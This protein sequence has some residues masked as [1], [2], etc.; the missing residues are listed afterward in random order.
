MIIDCFLFFDELDLLE[1]RLHEL[2][3]VVDVFVLTESPITFTGIE[4]PLFFQENKDRFKGFEIV[5][6]VCNDLAVC[7]PMERERIQKQYNLDA[8]FNILSPGD[9]IMQGDCDEI[10]KASVIKEAIKDDWKTARLSMTL[11]YYWL[12][13]R[14]VGAKR[15]YKNSRLF[16]PTERIEYN[17]RQNDRVDRVYQDAGWHFSWMGDMQNKLK[18]WGHAPEYNKAPFNTTEH[19]E[20]CKEQGLDFIM[21]KGKRKIDFEFME[22]IS[23]L[24][25]YVLENL[26][27]FDKWIKH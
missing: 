26:E 9:I 20:K 16:R 6:A 18:S 11:F 15:T 22:D 19:I 2:Q 4:K 13:C 27:R 25:Q 1:V 3:D 5:H 17:A 24:P 23:Y 8:A 14:E 7:L 21:R 10:P 12:N